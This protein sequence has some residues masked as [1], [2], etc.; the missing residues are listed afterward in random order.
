M[1]CSLLQIFGKQVY[2][3]FQERNVLGE[4]V[5]KKSRSITDD[6]F[7]DIEDLSNL[8]ELEIQHGLPKTLESLNIPIHPSLHPILIATT[9]RSDV[10]NRNS[11][12][13]DDDDND[14]NDDNSQKATMDMND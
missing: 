13:D 11:L 14:E 3:G 4:S 12:L 5:Q 2:K 1:L 6:R 7:S 8:F 10:F 9:R